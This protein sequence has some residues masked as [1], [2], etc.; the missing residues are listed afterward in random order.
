MSRPLADY[1]P[2]ESDEDTGDEKTEDESDESDESGEDEY[3]AEEDPN[4]LRRIRQARDAR[5]ALIRAPADGPLLTEEAPSAIKRAL[6]SNIINTP[7]GAIMTGAPGVVAPVTGAIKNVIV[8]PKEVALAA[9]MQAQSKSMNLSQQVR[10][11]RGSLANAP[12]FMDKSMATTKDMVYLDPPKTTKTSLFSLKSSNRDKQVYP[13][14]YNFQIKLPRVY[15]NV[16]KFQLVQLSFPNSAANLSQTAIFTSSLITA[17]L[18]KGIPSTCISTC[19]SVMNCT[20]QANTLGIIE[21]GRVNDVGDP[22]LVTLALSDGAYNNKQIAQEL[23]AKANRTPPFNLITYEAFRDVFMN[24]RDI[25]VLFNEPGDSFESDATLRRLGTHT[26][27]DIMNTYYSQQHVD[28]FPVITETI[29]FNAYYYPVLKEAL[30]TQRALPFLQVD[31]STTFE[32]IYQQVMGAFLGLDSVVYE[33]ICRL[34]QGA[35]D[36]Y[37][38]HLTF[39]L[40]NVNKYIWSY[41]ESDRRFRSVHDTLHPSLQREFKRKYADIVAQQLTAH[42]LQ[43]HSIPLLK[44]DAVS[45]ASLYKHLELNLSTVLSNYHM[46]S[47]YRYQGGPVHSTVESTFHVEDLHADEAFTTMFAYQSTIGRIYGNY[48]GMAMTFTNFLD[49]HSSLSGYYDLH[50]TVTNRLSSFHG[51]VQRDYHDYVSTKYTGVL[52]DQTI[53]TQTYTSQQSLPV[54]YVTNQSLY[55]PGQSVRGLAQSTPEDCQAICCAVIQDLVNS[56]YSCLPVDTAIRGLNYRM[57]L[58]NQNIT[59][60]NL[61]SSIADITSTGNTNFFI[62][63]N[64]EFGFNNMDIAM[65]ENYAVSNETTGQVK[66]MAAKILM[67]AIGDTGISQ[68]VIQNP[69]VLDVPLGKLDHLDFKIYYDDDQLTPAWQ[70]LPF[71]LAINEWDATFQIDEEVSFANRETGWGQLP[72]IPIPNDPQRLSYLGLTSKDNPN[73]NKT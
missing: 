21:A 26:K 69:V 41:S 68:T 22:L 61:L 60:F 25:L 19:I 39:E 47:G 27:E 64:T 63:M 67:G 56:W 3:V 55:L 49:Y 37:R 40:R 30:A 16:T 50:Q 12:F 17:L 5:Y 54:A 13:T 72:T 15:K 42:D 45:Y 73:N 58:V 57:G 62:Q 6:T 14:P 10:G 31:P 33:Q 24:T 44:K 29:A 48:G 35:L 7:T 28:S 70:Y 36:V 23:T 8:D 65:K 53:Q 66:L 71:T 20:T 51:H 38:R 43:S 34:N 9:H 46:V 4:E 11:N 18:E 2:Y 59:N 32:E 1:T 52:P